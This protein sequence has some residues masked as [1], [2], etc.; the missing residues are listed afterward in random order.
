MD[1]QR[2]IAAVVFTFSGLMLWEAW[3]K[4]SAPKVPA[5]APT[6][7]STPAAVSTPAANGTP[8]AAVSPPPPGAAPAVPAGAGAAPQGG[9]AAKGEP[10]ILRNDKFELELSTLGADIRRVTFNEIGSAL[11]NNKPLVLLQDDPKNLFITQSGLVG[12]GLP[13]HK[14]T[15]VLAQKDDGLAS[16]RD[17]VAARFAYK[18]AWGSRSKRPID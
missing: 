12:E 4:Q 6:V 9:I 3:Q 1:I 8:G 17:T 5:N 16:G 2:L 13:N 7:S 18:D 10:V 15:F 14:S 11:D